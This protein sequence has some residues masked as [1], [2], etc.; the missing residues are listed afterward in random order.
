MFLIV[1]L[2]HYK[3]NPISWGFITY[4]PANSPDKCGKPGVFFAMYVAKQQ[5]STII[6]HKYVLSVMN[7]KCSSLFEI[8]VM[9]IIK[10]TS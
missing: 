7:L 1:Y 9:N 3:F 10:S 4:S 5:V 6:E 2:L 8:F